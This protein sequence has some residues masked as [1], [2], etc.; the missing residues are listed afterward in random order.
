VRYHPQQGY[1]AHSQDPNAP[2]DYSL[3]PSDT[4]VQEISVLEDDD[5][6]MS[7]ESD[8]ESDPQLAMAMD[9]EHRHFY[10][11]Q[12]EQAMLY[13]Q[14]QRASGGVAPEGGYQARM[15]LG[16]KGKERRESR[17]GDDGEEDEDMYSDDGSS[18]A[19]IPD[20]EIDFGLTYALY[21]LPLPH[22]SEWPDE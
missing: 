13:Q 10:A 3:A 8:F 9:P 4:Q 20:E 5:S 12:Q 14:H 19:S 6:V 7:S 11:K 22:T 16:E 1:S 15:M 17:V 18:A 2:Q 21:V